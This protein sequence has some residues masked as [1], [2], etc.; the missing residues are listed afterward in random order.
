MS[1]IVI[2]LNVGGVFYTT[3]LRTLC[4]DPKSKLCKMFDQLR[5]GETSSMTPSPSS[6][7]AITAYSDPDFDD[8]SATA[9]VNVAPNG[10][11]TLLKDSKELN[12]L[13]LQFT[14][15]FSFTP[16]SAAQILK[17]FFSNTRL[18]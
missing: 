1:S 11:Q 3:S 14:M 4:T 17:H 7:G 13:T 9:Q 2:E 6:G 12:L 15:T 18:P 5:N 16:K 10:Y 8:S